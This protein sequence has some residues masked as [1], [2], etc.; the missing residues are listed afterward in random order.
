MRAWCQD[1]ETRFNQFQKVMSD[2]EMQLMHA[3]SELDTA[4]ADF[5]KLKRL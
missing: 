2:Q 3:R 1:L 5:H 4:L